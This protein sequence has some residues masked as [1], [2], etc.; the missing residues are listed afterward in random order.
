MISKQLQE[1]LTYA[2]ISVFLAWHA[3]ALMIAPL[4]DSSLKKSMHGVLHPYLRLFRLDNTWDFYAPNVGS[5]LQFRYVVEDGG[6]KQH[7]F[8]PTDDYGWFHPSYWWFRAW[9]NVIMDAPDLHGD[10]AVVL[11]CKKHHSLNPVSIT[12]KKVQQNDFSVEDHL[13]GKHP[14]DTE[15]VTES[16]LKRA[17]CPAK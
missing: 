2:A 10:L 4:P 13:T 6:G 1:R 3:L 11:L 5:G 12:L 14:M 16:E 8:K 17:T 15:F 7:T 9:H